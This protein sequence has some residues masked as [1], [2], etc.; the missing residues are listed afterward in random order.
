MY[1]LSV[2]SFFLNFIIIIASDH[3]HTLSQNTSEEL[4]MSC[5]LFYLLVDKKVF[6]QK[7][8]NIFPN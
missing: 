4:K 7:K 6:G 3:C 8:S 2:V 1:L 5:Q